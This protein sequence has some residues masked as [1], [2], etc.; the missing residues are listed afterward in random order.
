MLIKFS[1]NIK[2]KDVSPVDVIVNESICVF[3]SLRACTKELE[4]GSVY[5]CAVWDLKFTDDDAECR[6]MQMFE[7]GVEAKNAIFDILI[8]FGFS[9]VDINDMLSTIQ[10]IPATSSQEEE[11]K[12]SLMRAL[13]K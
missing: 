5:F 9:E 2:N 6:I 1:S 7:N 8:L 12:K 10:F 11:M 3:Q 4:K 13:L